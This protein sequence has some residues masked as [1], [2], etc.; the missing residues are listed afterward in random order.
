MGSGSVFRLSTP[1]F[2]FVS[3][4][5]GFIF[6]R[7]HPQIRDEIMECQISDPFLLTRKT[8]NFTIIPLL[9]KIQLQKQS[10]DILAT[11]GSIA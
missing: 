11:K 8:A 2:L 7:K 5:K 6:E 9:R 4:I 3:D 1:D 10:K